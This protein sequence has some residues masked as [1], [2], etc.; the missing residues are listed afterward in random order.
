[1]LKI[2][3]GSRSILKQRKMIK[4][5]FKIAL[6]TLLR[7]KVF[8][9]VNITGLALGLTC[10]MLILLYAK[11]EVSFDKF[12]QHKDQLFQLT[13]HR[14]STQGE[15]KHFA[16]AAMVQGPAFKRA[17][18][19]I[20]AFVRVNKQPVV[21]KKE[22][23]TFNEK[24]TWVD[25]NFFS[26]FSFPLLTGSPKTALSELHSVVLSEDMA[27]KYFGTTN[28][29]GKNIELEIEGKF[30][31]FVVTGVTK[32]A[33][34]NSSIK[35]SMLLPFKYLE[36]VHPD[37]GWMWVSYP[38]YFLL[39]PKSNTALIETKMAAVFET[40]AKEEIALNTQA[41]YHDKFIWGLQPFVDMH[42]NAGFEGAPEVSNPLYAYVLTGIALFILLIACINFINLTI[43]QSLKRGKEIGIRKVIGSQRNQLIKQF[44][45]ESLFVC[46]IAFSFALMLTYMLLPIFNE[47]ANKKLSLAYLFDFQLV[48]TYISL[49]LITGLV[50]GFYPALVLSGLQ[51]VETLYNKTKAVGKN[52]LAK[53]L[54]VLQ[55]SIASFLIIVT[56]FIYAQFDY[57]TKTDLGYND[58]NLLEMT[59]PSAIM[60]KPLMEVY[61][62][63]FSKITGVDVVSYRN[64]GHFG[65][66]TQAGNKEF[67]ATYMRVNDDYLSAL[68]VPLVAG[69]SFSK[70]FPADSLN[71]VVVNEAFVKA[72]GWND[73]I[74]KTVDFMN[75]PDWG[76]RKITVVGV[77]KDYH[78]QSLKEKIKPL[79]FTQEA[80]LPLGEFAI[81]LKPNNI[82]QTLTAIE[83]AY[84]KL[85]P[86]QPFEYD[87]KDDLNDKN[88]EAEAK[89][90]QII[91]FSAIVTIF[92]SCIGLFGLSLFSIQ[93]RTK[94]VGIR[95]VFGA[96]VNQI[97]G[98]I[99][100]DFIKLVALAFVI[101][102]PLAWYSVQK[103][104]QNFAYRIDMSWS[105]FAIAGI[106]ALLI[107]LITVSYNAIK[108]AVV[109]PVSSLRGE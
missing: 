44:L 36:E 45:G 46:F 70:D 100:L 64:V 26:V 8:S 40:E 29:I 59:V 77:A 10:C 41:G 86:F 51:P 83:K 7:N 81:R 23:S 66:K 72:A 85:S 5:Y 43:A 71:S 6:R 1:M 73:A 42:L 88:Y 3:R 105:V 13:C 60:N 91:T 98:L 82:P 38:T 74:G 18:P 49:F 11:D 96:S 19:E 53:G 17:I 104:L 24:V 80:R 4:N 25:D 101:A 108:A 21:V 57:L 30:E 94:E 68:Q 61:K 63:E 31:L 58:K 103:W 33:P 65:G 37:N 15:D 2:L 109:N 55:F 28:A 67:V 54:V 95:K 48:A 12:H 32:K 9:F 47:L 92:I 16:I 97:V 93:K 52:Y 34:Q 78:D 27:E 39:N 90:K 87:F 76:N 14:L 62:S 102:T 84:Q 79:V 56:L 107:A 106:L 89:W 75:L 20:E 69:R 35:F 99:S 50:A 22:G